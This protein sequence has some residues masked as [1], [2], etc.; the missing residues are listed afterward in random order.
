MRMK[1]IFLDQKQLIFAK[2]IKKKYQQNPSCEV[3]E[4]SSGQ[5][6]KLLFN[7][8]TEKEN[9]ILYIVCRKNV[10]TIFKEF[11]DLF[12]VIKAGG[13]LVHT[14]NRHYLLIYR[15]DKWDLPKGKKESKF[16]KIMETARRE[17]MEET[18]ISDLTILRKLPSTYHFYMQSN[19]YILKKCVW[20]E[21]STLQ[22][23]QPVPQQEENITD[24]KWL[25]KK[26]V[27]S[28]Y[29][30][31]YPSIQWLIAQYFGKKK[32]WHLFAGLFQ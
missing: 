10:K 20:F 9:Q 25:T 4:A 26:Q 16:E 8:F 30:Q 27:K 22:K 5:E 3:Y 32:R 7:R 2:K 23:N 18:G 11:T 15:N 24:A 29:P 6:A 14:R 19:Q 12:T 13:G 1:T 21:M 17:V 31:M 28:Y